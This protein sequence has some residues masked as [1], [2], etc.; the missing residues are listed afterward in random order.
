MPY[1]KTQILALIVFTTAATLTAA[2]ESAAYAVQPEFPKII[3]Q[4]EDQLVP[5]G[6]NAT[7]TV[8]A[9]NGRSL[10]NGSAMEMPLTGR[11][12]TALP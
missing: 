3:I 7:F 5:I 11:P 10:I 4:P 1:M 2:D 12:M 8:I 9:T 6:S